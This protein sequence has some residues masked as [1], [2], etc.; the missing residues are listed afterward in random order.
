M[1]QRVAEKEVE[2]GEL[3]EELASALRGAGMSPCVCVCACVRACVRCV[4][5]GV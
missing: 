2:I 5:C 1:G 3:R 4:V